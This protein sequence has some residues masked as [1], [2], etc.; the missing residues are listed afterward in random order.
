MAVLLVVLIGVLAQTTTTLM[1]KMLTSTKAGKVNLLAYVYAKDREEFIMSGG[2]TNNIIKESISN[3]ENYSESVTIPE[4]GQGEA[5]IEIYYKNEDFPRCVRYVKLQAYS[6]LDCPI[7][8]IIAWP[9]HTLPNEGGTWL[10]CNGNP[11]PDGYTALRKLIGNTTPAFCGTGTGGY[12]LRG[13]GGTANASLME[14]QLDAEMPLK[15]TFFNYVPQNI[16][17]LNSLINDKPWEAYKRGW[18]TAGFADK[19]GPKGAF[20]DMFHKGYSTHIDRMDGYWDHWHHGDAWDRT[21]CYFGITNSFDNSYKK[22]I[23]GAD[24]IGDEARP[25]NAAVNFIIKAR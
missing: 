17:H 5:K 25:I 1:V 3:A 2:S 16:A 8:T 22:A 4:N 6:T 19:Y 21:S 24:K 10:L 23:Y 15:G 18:W 14:E 11:I 7:G 13:F 9:S 12:F 20:Y